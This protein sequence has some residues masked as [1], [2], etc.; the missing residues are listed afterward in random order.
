MS[1]GRVET[2]EPC[3]SS[4]SSSS[5]AKN[6]QTKQEQQSQQQKQHHQHHHHRH[7]QQQ[8]QQ[9]HHHHQRKPRVKS[10]TSES[11]VSAGDASVKSS[12]RRYFVNI[13]YWLIIFLV[14]LLSY[15]KTSNQYNNI[16]QRIGV[17]IYVVTQ[18]LQEGEVPGTCKIKIQKDRTTYL[19]FF[20]FL[21][22]TCAPGCWWWSLWIEFCML[23]SFKEYTLP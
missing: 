20:S 7:H 11:L 21:P 14:L 5:L 2:A 18:T 22:S 3:R 10:Q 9:Q 19:H 4:S 1:D 17:V 23:P 13:L 16:M 15:A 6:Q 12:E 8:N